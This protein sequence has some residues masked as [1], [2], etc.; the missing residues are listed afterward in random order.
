MPQG[1]GGI[2]RQPTRPCTRVNATAPAIPPLPHAD[3]RAGD[4][5]AANSAVAEA[6]APQRRFALS[7]GPH[8]GSGCM[9]GGSQGAGRADRVKGY[10]PADL[11]FDLVFLLGTDH[12]FPVAQEDW[13]DFVGVPPVLRRRERE[14]MSAPHWRRDVG[15]VR[16]FTMA[17]AVRV[18]CCRSDDAP[19]VTFS[20]PYTAK[21]EPSAVGLVN[22]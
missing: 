15:L 21:E 9:E 16:T 20:G 18:A 12:V 4:Q 14:K 1:R 7:A 8:C 3:R 13:A 2:T 19:L 11:V 10:V 5:Q 17:R 6:P 22:V